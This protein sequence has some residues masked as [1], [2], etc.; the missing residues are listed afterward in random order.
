MIEDCHKKVDARKDP[1]T[2]FQVL[3]D[4]TLEPES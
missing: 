1:H 4:K 3:K 2:T